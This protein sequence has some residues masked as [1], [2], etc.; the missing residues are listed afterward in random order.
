ML[1]TKNGFIVADAAAAADNNIK[2]CAPFELPHTHYQTHTHTHR[3]P[4][5]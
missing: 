4:H 2:A 5:S 1:V 3:E